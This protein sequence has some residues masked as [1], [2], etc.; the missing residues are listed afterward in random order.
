MTRGQA[1]NWAKVACSGTLHPRRELRRRPRGNGHRA[2]DAILAGRRPQFAALLVIILGAMV[3]ACTRDNAIMAM[4]PASYTMNLP[5]A[6]TLPRGIP[7]VLS[8]D[9]GRTNF[10][11]GI[12]LTVEGLPTG[13]TGSFSPNPVTTNEAFLVL[14]LSAAVPGVYNTVLVR[15]TATGLADVTVPITLTITVAGSVTTS[16]LTSKVPS[17]VCFPIF[18]VR[19][20]G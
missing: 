10:T 6:P 13:I 16:G 1:M 15:G 17:L 9:F 7:G 19:T 18:V 20:L 11:G 8:I 2:A 14:D 3:Q 4:A 12:T 5:R